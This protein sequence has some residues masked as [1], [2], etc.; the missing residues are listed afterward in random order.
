MRINYTNSPAFKST[1]T[2]DTSSATSKRQIFI[3]GALM[4][5]FWLNNA[6]TTFNKIRNT[7]V[8]GKVDIYVK[9]YRDNAFESILKN[10]SISYKKKNDNSFN[11]IV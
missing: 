3:L 10:N 7:G 6:S 5:N 8:Y 4:N 11:Y 2:V 9:D 1:Y